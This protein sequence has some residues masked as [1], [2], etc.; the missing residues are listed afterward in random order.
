MQKFP[1]P[2]TAEGAKQ[3]LTE[4][5]EKDKDENVCYFPLCRQPRRALDT[6][7]QPP[8]FCSPEH[9]SLNRIRIVEK[10]QRIA[11]SVAN[12]TK[13]AQLTASAFPQSAHTRIVGS[14]EQLMTDLEQ[15]K[16]YLEKSADPEAVSAAIQNA[17]KDAE[18]KVAGAEKVASDEHVLRVAAEEEN[19]Q[20]QRELQDLREATREAI[21]R[22][23][24]AEADLEQLQQETGQR[25]AEMENERDKAIAVIRQEAQR[26]IDEM[27]IKLQ[28]A[29][30]QATEAQEKEKQALSHASQVERLAEAKVAGA[31]KRADD[32]LEQIKR[33]RA[34]AD[35]QKEELLEQI[36]RER[37]SADQQ[38][39]ELLQRLQREQDAADQQKQEYTQSLREERQRGVQDR[40]NYE[41]ALAQE[42]SERENERKRLQQELTRLQSVADAATKRADELFG[43]LRAQAKT[44]EQPPKS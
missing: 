5:A 35:Q 7:G 10:L 44:R 28:H 25:L 40:E 42:R 20:A 24:R 3:M 39:E 21:A 13:D 31:E 1:Y 29:T 36:K 33:E 27:L 37:T 26:Q 19:T 8:K 15:Y 2:S 14:V 11:G 41:K 12:N 32:L 17:L 30:Q 4:L 18:L 34:A 43:E 9:T 38:K 23:E 22:M 6:S 16:A